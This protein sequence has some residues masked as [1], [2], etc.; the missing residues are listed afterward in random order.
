MTVTIINAV[1]TVITD[2]LPALVALAIFCFFVHKR[3]K[4]RKAAMDAWL[5]EDADRGDHR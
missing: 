1:Y 3:R 4:E 5:Q 2:L